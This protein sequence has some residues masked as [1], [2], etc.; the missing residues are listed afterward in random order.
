MW[1]FSLTLSIQSLKIYGTSGL[2]VLFLCY[3]HWATPLGWGTNRNWFNNFTSNIFVQ[4]LLYGFLPVIQYW[5][6]YLGISGTG[7]CIGF[8]MDMCSWG[9][10][11]WKKTPGL[12]VVSSSW[13][14]KYCLSFGTFSFI[15]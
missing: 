6:W 14:S 11:F 9:V 5:Y 1:C 3:N 13:S 8:V 4:T 12:K 7:F 15:G 2:P 10:Y